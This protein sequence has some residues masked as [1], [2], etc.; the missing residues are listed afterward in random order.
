MKVHHGSTL[1]MIDSYFLPFPVRFF[2]PLPPVVL[3]LLVLIYA[4]HHQSVKAILKLLG[5][6]SRGRSFAYVGAR[7]MTL[8]FSF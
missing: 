4:Y 5:P 1:I 2:Y 3:F 8:R 7:G 6:L